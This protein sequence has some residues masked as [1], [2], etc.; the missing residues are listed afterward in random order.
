MLRA[1]HCE[2]VRSG[3]RRRYRVVVA[4]VAWAALVAS[5]ARL[6]AEAAA[7]R[8]RRE[9]GCEVVPA[10]AGRDQAPT[11]DSSVAVATVVRVEAVT[12]AS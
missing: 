10:V 4:A 2:S 12:V 1:C 11:E 6:A 7:A 9:A 3:G 8:A 5:E